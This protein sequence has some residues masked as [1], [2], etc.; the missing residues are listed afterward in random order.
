MDFLTSVRTVAVRIAGIAPV[1]QDHEAVG[2]EIHQRVAVIAQQR[3]IEGVDEA[4]ALLGRGRAPRLA[5]HQPGGV[6]AVEIRQQHVGHQRIELRRDPWRTSRGSHRAR[7]A[8]ASPNPRPAPAGRACSGRLS[9][10][11]PARPAPAACA[12]R[13]KARRGHNRPQG[14]REQRSDAQFGSLHLAFSMGAAGASAFVG[15]EPGRPALREIREQLDRS[16]SP[17]RTPTA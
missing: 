9:P 4:L 3:M 1:G 7:P 5:Q 13:A 12:P 6:F 10:P 17:A 11:A 16:D 14:E 15:A 2:R 8:C